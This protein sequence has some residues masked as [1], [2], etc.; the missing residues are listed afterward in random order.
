MFFSVFFFLFDPCLD[1]ALTPAPF[2]NSSVFVTAYERRK[3]GRRYS[4][5]SKKKIRKR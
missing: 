4:P 2:L 5:I 1:P 3:V